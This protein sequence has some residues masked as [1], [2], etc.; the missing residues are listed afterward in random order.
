MGS[1]VW[2]TSK[3]HN[4]LH[5]MW[6]ILTGSEQILIHTFGQCWMTCCNDVCSLDVLRSVLCV[7][8]VCCLFPRVWW[9][10]PRGPVCQL[11][12]VSW[13]TKSLARSWRATLR[14]VQCPKH[15][16]ATNVHSCNSYTKFTSAICC[17]SENMHKSLCS[18]C[19]C[20][21]WTTVHVKPAYILSFLILHF[22]FGALN[23]SWSM[24]LIPSNSILNHK[25]SEDKAV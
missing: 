8:W 10:S 11:L 13:T 24:S 22:V 23:Q 20:M 5:P 25:E 19:N 18:Q 9:S 16:L 6:Y 1:G 17:T 3:C 14:Y 7:T 15:G 21:F 2:I 12:V 4:S